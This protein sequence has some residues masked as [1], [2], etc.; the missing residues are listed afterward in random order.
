MAFT[1]RAG[2]MVGVAHGP[3]VAPLIRPALGLGDDMVY[4][5]GRLAASLNTTDRLL[6]QHHKPQFAP[7][8]PVPPAVGVRAGFMLFADPGPLVVLHNGR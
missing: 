6:S 8:W 3:K 2:R 4:V 1:G 5:R 7:T